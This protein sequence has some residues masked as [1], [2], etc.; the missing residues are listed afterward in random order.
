MIARLKRK[1]AVRAQNSFWM[2]RLD[3]FNLAQLGAKIRLEMAVTEWMRDQDSA[4]LNVVDRTVQKRTANPAFC[5]ACIKANDK[6]QR[7]VEA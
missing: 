5:P 7:A 6:D 1:P 2:V 4:L 3:K